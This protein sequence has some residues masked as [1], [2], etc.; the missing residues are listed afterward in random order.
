MRSN[1]SLLRYESAQIGLINPDCILR[2]QV[3]R[4]K[5]K[6]IP[7]IPDLLVSSGHTVEAP[8]DLI[9]HVP[10]VSGAFLQI[11]VGHHFEFLTD[12]FFFLL[13]CIINAD[14]FFPRRFDRFF[15]KEII[16][17]YGTVRLKNIGG[18]LPCAAE[19][20]LVKPVKVGGIPLL[21]LPEMLRFFFKVRDASFFKQRLF[22]AEHH[23]LQ[24]FTP[25]CARKTHIL[26]HHLRITP[27]RSG[28]AVLFLPHV[29]AA[30]LPSNEAEPAGAAIAADTVL[31]DSSAQLTDSISDSALLVT[32]ALP[33][34]LELNI[35]DEAE[36]ELQIKNNPVNVQ[37]SLRTAGILAL[38]H[39]AEQQ[40]GI[41]YVF[42]S[43]GPETFDCSGLVYY[44]LNKAGISIDR[45]TAAGY[46]TNSDWEKISS[47]DDLQAGDILFFSIGEE[48]VGHTAIYAGNGE[49][50][51][52]SVSNGEVVKRSC[53]TSYW[54][55]NFVFARRP[56]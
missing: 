43:A 36:L 44:C 31:S 17:G 21:H 4:D 30:A 35:S 2:C 7:D 16:A 48:S 45:T 47:M 20:R 38:L 18:F 52:A 15:K 51:D 5:N 8:D 11:R 24:Y 55:S 53:T 10:D 25:S 1:A 46:S 23:R 54:T 27:F 13:D 14:L 9:T 33:A 39:A 37:E 26:L 19:C 22:L 32:P 12:L 56:F 34:D 41:P 49:M 40:L 6:G 29:T 28:T 50:I 3:F 42:A